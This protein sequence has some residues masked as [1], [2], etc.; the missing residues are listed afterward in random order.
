MACQN[1]YHQAA[2][3]D[4]NLHVVARRPLAFA[5]RPQQYAT[6]PVPSLAEYEQLWVAWDMVTQDMIPEGHMLS[7]PIK[8]RNPCLFYL[9][10]IPAFLDIHMTRATCDPATEPASYHAMF[11]RG[12]DPDVDDPQKCHA[13][14]GIPDQWPATKDILIYQ[15][16]VRGRVRSLYKTIDFAD[17]RRLGRALWLTFEHEGRGRDV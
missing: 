17:S 16:N 12:I 5:S 8:L 7:Q 1:E 15:E 2:T 13:N 10:H 14:S 11:E 6:N 4:G 3:I 9:G